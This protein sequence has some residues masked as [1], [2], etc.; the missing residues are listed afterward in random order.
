LTQF[1]RFSEAQ[2]IELIISGNHNAFEEVFCRYQGLL[3]AHAFNK[4]QNRDEALDVVQEVLTKMWNRRQQLD[5]D[6]NLA[7]YLFTAI[8]NQ[9]FDLLR[10]KKNIKI[11][12]ESFSAF[13][14]QSGSNS[15]HL[16][17]E[18]QFAAIIEKEIAA[19]PSRMREVFELKRK[20]HLSNKEIAA[21]MNITEATV[22]DQM[23]KALRRL[24]FKLGFI[25][26]IML[27]L[28]R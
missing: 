21:L 27:F 14:T 5:A 17:R 6:G 11:Y 24:R 7:G 19:L 8:R 4:L 18:R 2:L 9:V 26:F 25:W 12:E 16:V 23:K 13:A 1:S 10:H 20:Q 22:A 28:P 15:D 3:Y